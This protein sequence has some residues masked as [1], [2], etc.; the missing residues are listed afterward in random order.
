MTER[1]SLSV[2]AL[3]VRGDVTPISLFSGIPSDTL[4]LPKGTR[5]FRNVFALLELQIQD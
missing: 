2:R 5:M 1:N 4:P 3:A